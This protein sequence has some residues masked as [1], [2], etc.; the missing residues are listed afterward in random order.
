M[1]WGI[2]ELLGTY[3]GQRIRAAALIWSLL[4][5]TSLGQSGT[6][7]L[8]AAFTFIDR[9]AEA[10]ERFNEG[11][12]AEALT[13]FQGL[14]EKYPEQDAD[15]YVSLSMGDCLFALDRLDEAVTAYQRTVSQHPE[16]AR[17]VADR[18][19]EVQLARPV[20]D[21]LLDELRRSVESGSD[22]QKR[23]AELLDEAMEAFKAA[24]EENATPLR[25]QLLGAHA[26]YLQEL[27]IDL[28]Q[29]IQQFESICAMNLPDRFLINR[30]A[31][32]TDKSPRLIAE[33]AQA[34]QVLRSGDGQRYEVH[35]RVDGPGA[36]GQVIVNGRPVPLTEAQRK[37]IQRHY[38]RINQIYLEAY[39]DAARQ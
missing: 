31:S 38:D 3:C 15:G 25:A 22:L 17:P 29:L 8:D 18:L 26:T 1:L 20:T 32:R 23:A 30:L 6:E 24:A 11:R 33:R 35:M 28:A 5:T 10:T 7:D 39:M 12:P 36:E 9:A 13:I 37:L 14:L 19:A 27:G 2:D 34:Q 4:A 16:L 21:G